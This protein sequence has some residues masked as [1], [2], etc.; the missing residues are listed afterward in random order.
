MTRYN[1]LEVTPNPTWPIVTYGQLC[2]CIG[3]ILTKY[4]FLKTN[5][6]FWSILHLDC[7]QIM[8]WYDYEKWYLASQ[9]QT[10]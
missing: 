1:F 6:I 2:I 4:D 8:T 9:M 3:Q 10:L 5:Y 7:V